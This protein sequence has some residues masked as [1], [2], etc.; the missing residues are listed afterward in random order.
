MPWG[1]SLGPQPL[2]YNQCVARSRLPYGVG[3]TVPRAAA[4]ISRERHKIKTRSNISLSTIEEIERAIATLS[5][6]ELERLYS[7]LDAYHPQPIDARIQ[8]DL[9]AGRLD[10]AIQQALDDEERLG[11]AAL[12]LHAAFR[13]EGLLAEISSTLARDPGSRG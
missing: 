2:L 4:N 5:P 6:G 7:W 9:A 1:G 13:H 3:V 12:A 8:S 10:H 11:R